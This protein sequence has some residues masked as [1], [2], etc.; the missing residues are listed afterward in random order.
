MCSMMNDA[1]LS[2]VY[3]STSSVLYVFGAYCLK[4]PAGEHAIPAPIHHFKT[5]LLLPPFAAPPLPLLPAVPLGLPLEA[6]REPL[7]VPEFFGFSRFPEALLL[8]P[9]AGPPA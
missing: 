5:Y 2:R 6:P 3:T 7:A 1:F 8:P 4:N 9:L